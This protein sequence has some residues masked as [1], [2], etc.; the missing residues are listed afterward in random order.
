[1]GSQLTEVLSAT[2]KTAAIAL[3]L[4]IAAPGLG[5]AVKTLGKYFSDRS[6]R[7]KQICLS[8]LQR[9]GAKPEDFKNANEFA[10][11]AWRLMR[12][13]RD[14]AADENLAILAQAMACLAKRHELCSSEFV[15]VADVLAPLGRD[16][17]ILLGA[18]MKAESNFSRRV[19]AERNL[20]PHLECHAGSAQ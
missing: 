6:Q 20:Q 14:Q 17:L 16:E 8:E 12:A 3:D 11:E 9:S 13:V 19:Q 1:M 2:L 18:L 10:A 5:I 15:R 4:H 7:A